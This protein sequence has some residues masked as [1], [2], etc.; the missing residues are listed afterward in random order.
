MAEDTNNLIKT[1]T[2]KG[3]VGVMIGLILLAGSSIWVTY[4]ITT[5]HLEHNQIA[6]EAQ[7]VATNE[8]TRVL[9]KLITLIEERLR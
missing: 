7:T 9:S 5:N 6:W 3:L 4:K 2:S 1:L 8:N